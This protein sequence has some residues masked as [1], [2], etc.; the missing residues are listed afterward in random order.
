[1]LSCETKKRFQKAQPELW[2]K[3]R[4]DFE[5]Q[6]RL[7]WVPAQG[8]DCY[9][10]RLLTSWNPR[11]HFRTSSERRQQLSQI[12]SL[13]GFVNLNVSKFSECALEL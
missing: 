6:E 3:E 12:S 7:Q 4:K 10:Q 9:S 1:M 5:A 11:S 8:G 2:R 13:F